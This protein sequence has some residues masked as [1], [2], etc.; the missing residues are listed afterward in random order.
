MNARDWCDDCCW[1]FEIKGGRYYKQ[2]HT[3]PCNCVCH[4]PSRLLPKPE[5]QPAPSRRL[6]P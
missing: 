5:T 6:Y 3:H 2:I 4:H 1:E